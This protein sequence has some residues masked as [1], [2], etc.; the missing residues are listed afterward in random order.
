VELIAVG[1]PRR[2]IERARDRDERHAGLSDRARDK[3]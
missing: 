2:E 1:G 3:E